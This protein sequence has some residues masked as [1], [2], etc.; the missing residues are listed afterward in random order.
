MTATGAATSI[1]SIG[2]TLNGA[3]SGS[4]WYYFDVGKTT[5]YGIQTRM[6]TE[7]LSSAT[8]SVSIVTPGSALV[9]HSLYHYRIVSG[10]NAGVAYGVDRTFTTT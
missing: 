8:K 3:N 9:P 7:N 5:A 10:S 2:A 1:N 4:T 6:F